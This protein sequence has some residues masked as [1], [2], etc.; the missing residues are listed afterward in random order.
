M[1]PTKETIKGYH[2]YRY[3]FLDDLSYIKNPY[4][5]SEFKSREETDNAIRLVKEI[6]LECG[7]E[8]DGDIGIMWL[9]PFIDVGLEDS[10][11]AYIWHVKQ[12]NNGIS[13]LACRYPLDF[14]RLKEQNK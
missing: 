6:F 9:P 8:G 4:D 12:S 10:V 14:E 2:V 7:W 5:C 1:L 11:G 13:F 3:T